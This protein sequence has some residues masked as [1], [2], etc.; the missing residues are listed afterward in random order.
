MHK[1]MPK[2]YINSVT[3]NIKDNT[4]DIFLFQKELESINIF[5]KIRLAYAL[6]NRINHSDSILYKVRNGSGWVTDFDDNYDWRN[7]IVAKIALKLVLKSISKDLASNVQGETIYIPKNVHY[8]LPSTEKQFTGNFP[9]G[10]YFEVDKDIIVGIHWFDTEERV[11]LDLAMIGVSGKTGWDSR[12]R[13]DKNKILFS[14]DITAA[15]KPKGATELFYI[16]SGIEESK[17]ITL[18]YYNLNYNSNDDDVRCKIILAKERPES[19]EQNYMI[20]PKNIIAIANTNINKKS[21]VIGLL[22]SVE[23]KTRFYFSC[24][25]TDNSISS[26]YNDKSQ[27]IIE[28]YENTLVNS[29]ELKDILIDAGANLIDNIENVE[30]FNDLVD[31][32]PMSLDKNTIIDLIK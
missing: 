15:P 22:A 29:I 3:S 24:T 2:D 1:P 16:K 11:D 6:K 31:L 19:F 4:F 14:G 26:G 12:Y 18:N 27:K 25:R 28:F 21:Y 9:S 7:S 10:S 5:R 32:S 8:T 30:N 17:I 23:N 13:S 20:D